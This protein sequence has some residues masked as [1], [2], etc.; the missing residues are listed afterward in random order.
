MPLK[1]FAEP[2]AILMWNLLHREA[3]YLNMRPRCKGAQQA[4]P[5]AAHGFPAEGNPGPTQARKAC[6]AGGSACV[7]RGHQT[8]RLEV[9]H[10]R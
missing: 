3:S 4:A 5:H 1:K 7:A 9:F 8:D 6:A 2:I 10:S